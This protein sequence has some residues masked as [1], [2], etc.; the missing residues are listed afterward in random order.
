M[1]RVRDLTIAVEDRDFVEWH[2]GIPHAY[3]WGFLL[4][5]PVEAARRALAPLLLP[6]YRRQPH[7]TVAYAGLAGRELHSRRLACDLTVLRRLCRG[8][9]EVAAQ[10]WSSFASAAMLEVVGPWAQAAH[11][12]LSDGLEWR[13]L[14]P[15]VPHVTVGF[16]RTQVPISQPLEALSSVALPASRWTPARLQLLRYDTCDI[17]GPLTVVAEL[18]LSN[19]QFKTAPGW[20]CPAGPGN[21]T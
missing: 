21:A 17:A 9:V 16:Y 7:L 20:V 5:C 15:Y 1:H 18:D 8:P 2:G 3:V 12:V 6:D 14:E 11:R 4:D 19:G 10:R 13:R